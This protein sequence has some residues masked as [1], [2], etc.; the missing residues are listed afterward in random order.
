MQLRANRGLSR[1]RLLR[2]AGVTAALVLGGCLDDVPIGDVEADE[3][4]DDG[5]DSDGTDS[6]TD[7]SDRSQTGDPGDASWNPFEFDR[8]IT[9]TYETYSADEGAGTLVWDV[10]DVTDEE[11]TVTLEYETAETQFETTVSG[12]KEDLQSDLILTPAGTFVLA[13]LFSP[14]MGYYEG[15]TLS[16]GDEWSYSSPDGSMRFAIIERRT[17]AGVECYASVTEVDGRTVH[18]GCFAPDLG[19]APYTVYYDEN[20]ERSFELALVSV[21]T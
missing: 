3:D 6:G 9:Y 7:S 15:R 13:T 16:V 21:D 2:T 19:L 1:R 10:T 12:T 4:G 17:Y 20:G 14:T 11:A 8:P 18:E 5:G